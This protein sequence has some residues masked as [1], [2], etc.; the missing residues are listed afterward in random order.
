MLLHLSPS[1]HHS[2]PPWPVALGV[3]V[4]MVVLVL[5]VAEDRERRRYSQAVQRCLPRPSDIN[6]TGLKSGA[7]PDQKQ[8]AL[9]DAEEL[10]R[11]EMVTMLRNDLV[12]HP[13]PGGSRNKAGQKAWR[14]ALDEEPLE[15]FT[16]EELVEVGEEREGEGRR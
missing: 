10:I 14:K 8:K 6:L 1:S 3:V 4:N 7:H 13:T 11:A 15:T 2:A 12:H 9:F 16:D 5:C